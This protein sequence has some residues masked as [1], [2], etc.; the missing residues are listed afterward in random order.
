MSYNEVPLTSTLKIST[1]ILS[2]PELISS[3]EIIPIMTGYPR[4]LINGS[5]VQLVLYVEAHCQG[6]V[7]RST[8]K[9]CL[10]LLT[11]ALITLLEPKFYK[12]K[13]MSG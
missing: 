2:K 8:A 12:K 13:T 10:Y 4:E 11:S 9:F 5:T 6:T 3:A 7:I 1:P